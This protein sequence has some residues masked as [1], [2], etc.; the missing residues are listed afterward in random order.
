MPSPNPVSSATTL[1]FGVGD[2]GRV[3]LAV[4]DVAGRR[5]ALLEDGDHAAGEFTQV[6]DGRDDSGRLVSPGIYVVRIETGSFEGMRKI[7]RLK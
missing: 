2:A 3:R 7:V 5:V 1:R 6:W 4:Y